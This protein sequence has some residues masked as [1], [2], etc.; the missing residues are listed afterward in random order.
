[1]DASSPVVLDAPCAGDTQISVVDLDGDGAR[2]VVL[3]LG[4][5]ESGY[6]LV[7]LW[8]DGSGKL[9]ASAFA[10]LVPESE[11]PNA[12]TLLG[13]GSRDSTSIVYTT[14]GAV[15]RLR[16]RE[17]ERR[18]FDDAGVIATV[19]SGTGVVAADVDGDG[20]KDLAVADNGAVRILRAELEAQ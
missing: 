7:T 18:I 19:L 4:V 5:K 10:S 2:D 17:N 8:G 16:A 9:D 1:V 12:Y 3:L 11:E 20:V 14:P 15:R 6:G 13:G